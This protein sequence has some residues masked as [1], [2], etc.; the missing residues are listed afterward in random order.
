MS[1][2]IAKETGASPTE[3]SDMQKLVDLGVDSRKSVEIADS[4]STKLCVIFDVFDLSDRS[5]TVGGVMEKLRFVTRPS[6][7]LAKS[8]SEASDRGKLAFISRRRPTELTLSLYQVDETKSL[9]TLYL[10]NGHKWSLLT[11]T[12]FDG[13]KDTTATL[14]GNGVEVSLNLGGRGIQLH[15]SKR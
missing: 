8:D 1:G 2:I 11:R 9:S 5:M 7:S 12:Y 6:F 10:R 3:L 15:I 4:L 14:S 13:Y